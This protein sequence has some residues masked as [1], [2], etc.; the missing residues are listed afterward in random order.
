MGIST[1]RW[2]EL[3]LHPVRIRILA[4]VAGDR[5]TASELA[6]LL[7]D[8]PQATLYRHIATLAKAGMLEVV[9]ERKVG[10][11]TE[12]VHALPKEGLTP[13]AEALAS[14]SPE[15]HARYFTA[16]VSTL[17]SEFSRYLTKEHIDLVADGVGYHQ[18]VLHLDEEELARFAQGF[19]ELVRPLLANEPGGNRTPRLLATILLPLTKG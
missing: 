7:P 10:G 3:A 15:E 11:A 17:L 2:A 14:A 16:F 12:R 9:E 1:E 18:L 6:G 19:A 5:R 13:S 8:V 4:A